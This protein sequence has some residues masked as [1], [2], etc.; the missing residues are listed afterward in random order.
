MHNDIIV[1]C[2][3]ANIYG[4]VFKYNYKGQLNAI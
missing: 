1:R 3:D 4:K 2:H